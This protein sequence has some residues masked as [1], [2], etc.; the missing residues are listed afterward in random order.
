M[1][2]KEM[3]AVELR[4]LDRKVPLLLPVAAVEQHGPHLPTATDSMI[5]EH[6]CLTA[7]A[8]LSETVLLL[9]TVTVGCSGHHLD[10]GG[11]LSVDHT[12]FIAYVSGILDSVAAAG[13]RDIVIFNSHGGNQAA[14]Q[15][16]VESWGM[17]HPKCR[18]VLLT[19][20]KLAGE[21]LSAITETGP[22]GVGHAGEF[23]TSLMLAI[24]PDL[25]RHDR[26]EKGGNLPTFPWA[27]SDMIRGAQ[28]LL[29]R[30]VRGMTS[31]GVFGDPTA[32]SAEKGRR[33][34]EAVVDRLKTVI[35][36]LGR[37]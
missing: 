9:P 1:K 6:L 32:A 17:S 30:P 24:A 25:V 22:G 18:V 35:A 12:T 36:D 8:E 19:W 4:A 10:F 15:V 21:A 14:A 29:H 20:W 33:I 13:F 5:A 31:N 7:E 16:M 11:T 23:E 2:W 34:A 27:E 28:G 3:T 37:G 26:I